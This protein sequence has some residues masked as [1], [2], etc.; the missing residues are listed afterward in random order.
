MASGR[1]NVGAYEQ[2]RYMYNLSE[3]AQ[4]KLGVMD[5]FLYQC[6]FT[7]Y[8]ASNS[9]LGLLKENRNPGNAVNYE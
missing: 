6:S 5:L 9:Q 4:I 3:L 2:V 7:F 8:L 1:V